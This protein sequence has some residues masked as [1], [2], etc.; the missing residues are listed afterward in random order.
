MDH[1]LFLG[2]IGKALSN[3][4]FRR[5][6]M[7]NAGS[8][9]G[10]WIYRTA[11]AWL[12]WELT[13]DPKWLGIIAF[14]DIFPMVMLS[15]VAGAISDR[16]GYVKVIRLSQFGMCLMGAG[17]SAAIYAGYLNIELIIGISIIHGTLEAMSTPARVSIVHAL[18][19]KDELSAAIALNSA[20][21]NATRVVGP[22]VG[23]ALLLWV[24]PGTVIALA[25]IAFIQFYIVMTFLKV[26][27]AGGDGR[28]SWE[29]IED[30]KAGVVYACRHKGIR[31]LMLMLSAVGLLIRPLMELAPAF[32]AEVFGRGPEGYALLLSS[33]GGGAMV[34]S[35]WMARRGRTEGLTPLVVSSLLVQGVTVVV[36]AFTGNIY[37]GSVF[38]AVMGYFMM[39]GGVG[40]QTLI[41]NAVASALRARV[42][43]IFILISWGLP[44]VGALVLGWVASFFGL[45]PTTAA[46]AALTLLIWLWARPLGSRLAPGLEQTDARGF[47]VTQ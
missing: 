47:R 19:T 3:R 33:I 41:Q 39:I 40:S 46:G 24:D 7:A 5:Y 9:V 13:E 1:N 10:R 35:L 22:A 37:V 27:A 4:P 31:F 11:V 12:V 30:M 23:G 21:F 2:G 25:T 44:A 43:S 6:W 17:F 14:A 32:A 16:I 34:G 26:E 42:M 38:L 8:I 36:F 18:V 45:Q 28:I 15:L 29:L 20:M